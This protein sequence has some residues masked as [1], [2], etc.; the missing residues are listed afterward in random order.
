MSLGGDESQRKA[1]GET[2]AEARRVEA[3][4]VACTSGGWGTAGS[5]SAGC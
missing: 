4:R 3:E 5:H 2:V 1:G